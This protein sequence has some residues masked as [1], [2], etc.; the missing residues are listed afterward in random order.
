M[1]NLTIGLFLIVVVLLAHLATQPVKA[2]NRILSAYLNRDANNQTIQIAPKGQLWDA[3]NIVATAS[4]LALTTNVVTITTNPAHGYVAGQRVTV[5]LLTGPTLF[6]DVNGTFVIASVPSSTTFTYALTHAN[7]VTGA[8][9]GSTTVNWLSTIPTGTTS[10]TLKY[11]PGSYSLIVIPTAATD[12]TYSYSSNAG[13]GGTYTLLQN[14]ANPI[15][16]SEGDTV[17]IQRTT[18]TPISF[19]F[20]CGR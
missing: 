13:I 9:T 15:Y 4:N 1:R 19:Q 17:Y 7:I 3:S 12:A 11:P 18:T 16:G 5:N 2:D 8:A 10:F 6:A 14:L 20:L